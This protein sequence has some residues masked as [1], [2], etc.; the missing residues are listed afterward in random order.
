MCCTFPCQGRQS[1]AT[2]QV[3][4][5]LTSEIQLQSNQ[6]GSYRPLEFP[7]GVFLSSFFFFFFKVAMKVRAT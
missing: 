1:V 4:K 3:Q 2:F 5:F 6:P 7:L